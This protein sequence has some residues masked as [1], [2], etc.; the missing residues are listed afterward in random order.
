MHIP[1]FIH[2]FSLS[3][4]ILTD[5]LSIV[6]FFPITIGSIKAKFEL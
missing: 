5:F 6:F 1:K 2:E 4:F 3:I